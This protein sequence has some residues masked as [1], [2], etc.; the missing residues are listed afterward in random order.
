MENLLLSLEGGK[1]MKKI[2]NEIGAAEE[3][4]EDIMGDRGL[5][6][7]LDKRRN[8]LREASRALERDSSG[9]VWILNGPFFVKMKKQSAKEVL[10][11]D[12]QNISNE[13]D[14]IRN[15]LK[16]KV[17]KLRDIENQP[18]LKGFDLKPLHRRE[19]SV[20]GTTPRSQVYFN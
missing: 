3:I 9:K 17:N 11:R 13:V 5:V 20:L 1:D 12:Q 15:G 10:L 7:E 4:A 2:L 8:A 18:S 16:E 19:L 6:V 14:T